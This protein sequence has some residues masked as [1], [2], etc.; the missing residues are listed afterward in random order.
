MTVGGIKNI[1]MVVA[2]V[3]SI[4]GC[5]FSQSIYRIYIMYLRCF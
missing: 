3:L 4:P 5:C 1:N 2:L